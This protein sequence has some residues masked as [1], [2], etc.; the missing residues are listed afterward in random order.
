MSFERMYLWHL[1][2]GKNKFLN[3]AEINCTCICNM[4][5]FFITAFAYE[6]CNKRYAWHFWTCLTLTIKLSI[7]CDSRRNPTHSSQNFT[8][9]LWLAVLVSWIGQCC[10]SVSQTLLRATVVRYNAKQSNYRDSIRCSQSYELVLG[11]FDM[12]IFYVLDHLT[13]FK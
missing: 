2:E 11:I 1:C 13:G 12:S 7:W 8:S 6:I 3:F 10:L 4:R 5:K 9:H